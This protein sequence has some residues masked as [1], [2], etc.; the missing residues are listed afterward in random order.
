MQ[1]RRP[2]LEVYPVHPRPIIKAYADQLGLVSLSNH[3]GPT[4][5]EVDAGTVV[6]GLV[7][8]TRSGRRPLSRVDECCAHQDTAR[9]LGKALPPH[10]FNDET[11][12]RVLERL[13]DLG[14]MKLCTAWAVRAATQC[15]FER[16]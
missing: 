5:M 13:D 14:T 8:E 15:G 10:A 9:L 11:V 12:G 16:R 2:A 3:D 6:L 7:V 4:A 1:D